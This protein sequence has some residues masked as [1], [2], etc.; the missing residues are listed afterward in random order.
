MHAYQDARFAFRMARRNPGFT[1]LAVLTLALGIGSTTAIFSVFKAV[2][3][4][5]LPYSRADRVVAL[6]Q[7]DP[8]TPSADGVSGRTVNEWRARARSFE[9]ISLYGDSQRTLID[10]GEAAVAFVQRQEGYADAPRPDLLFLDLNLPRL[11]GR[12]VLALI[13]S[14]ESLRQ[15]PVVIL[16]TSDAEED[17]IRSYDL[18]ANA[19]VTKPVDFKA[20]IDIVRQVDDFFL[21]VA[22]LPGR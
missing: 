10:N 18:H 17:V 2:L 21:S 19:F 8:T 14:D 11:D 5:Q 9:S 3:L 4:N 7:I 16:T 15:I 22:R 12:E 1:A 20:F 13:K 6:S